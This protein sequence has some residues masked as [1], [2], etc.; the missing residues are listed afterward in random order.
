MA[1]SDTAQ[2]TMSQLVSLSALEREKTFSKAAKALG[3]SQ[4]A[5][6][7]QLRNLQNKY[8]VCLFNRTGKSVEFTRLGKNLIQRVRRA[9]CII[10]DIE[11]TLSSIRE[12][13]TGQLSVG[14]SCQY[15]FM[16]LLALYMEKY[17][18]VQVDAN[19][20]DSITLVERVTNCDLDIASVTGIEAY[21]NLHNV[22]YD[23]QNIN[24]LVG[25]K[26]P[27]FKRERID[28]SELNGQRMV[29]RHQSSVT[30]IAF[31]KQ[32]EKKNIEARVVLELNTW[33]AVKEAVAAGIGFGIELESEFP[34]GPRLK[35]I[36]VTGGNF[37]V[38]QYF[39]CLPDLVKVRPVEAFLEIAEQ[40]Q[41]GHP[42]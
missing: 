34:G 42:D 1:K 9:L 41:D 6:S 8:G 22:L 31:E 28:I 10:E 17:P 16:K 32:L 20:G 7:L 13:K 37:I 18:Q 5:I 40:Y 4:P 11:N 26:H 36:K 2:I 19:L 35:K 24:V 39:I 29:A 38:N 12:L 23:Q 14:T 21:P 25:E 33:E 27:W 15:I 3:V 30:R